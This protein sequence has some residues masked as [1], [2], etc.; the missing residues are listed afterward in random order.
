MGDAD[1]IRL[2]E[3]LVKSELVSEEKLEERLIL[4]RQLGMPVGQIL[5]QSKDVSREQLLAAVQFQA[6]ILENALSTEKA[7]Q[8]MKIVSKQDFEFSE[9]LVMLGLINIDSSHR[10]GELLMAAGHLTEEDLA[11]A[12]MTSAEIAVPLGHVLVQTG[13]VPPDVIGVALMVQKQ[14]RMHMLT[15]EEGIERIRTQCPISA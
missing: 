4:A 7:I 6:L 5:V 13:V 8:G 2:G 10:L 11:F 3:L 15:P 9:V 12:L 14:V 1:P